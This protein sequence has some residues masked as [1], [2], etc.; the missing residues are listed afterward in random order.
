MNYIDVIKTFSPLSLDDIIKTAKL[1]VPIAYQSVPW[2]YPGLNHGTAILQDEEQLC[3]YLAAYGEMH[4]GKL[5]CALEK[6][7]FKS[8]D[9]NL[10]II[11]WG[12]G[13]GLASVYMADCLRHFGL[14][15]KLQKVTLIEPSTVALS[16]AQLH[17][18]QAVGNDVCLE[19]LNCY[20]PSIG[21]TMHEKS[22]DKL[23]IEE[24]ICIHLFSNILDIP[25]IDLKKLALLVS[26]SGY[27]HYFVCVGPVNF[28][29]DRLSAFPRYFDIQQGNFFIDFKAGQ[30]RQLPSGK[31]YGC[32]AKGFQILREEGKPFLI[33]LSYYPPKQFRSAFRLDVIEEIDKTRI[34]I[35]GYWNEYSAFE[36]LAP[37][38][39]GASIYEDID[40]LLAVLSNIVTRGLPTKC[41]PFIEDKINEVFHCSEITER[42]GTIRYGIKK[43]TNLGNEQLLRDIP[44]AISRIEKVIIEAVLT[45]HISLSKDVWNVVVKEN[46]VPCSAMAFADLAMMYNHLAALSVD[47]KDRKFPKV[48]LNVVSKNYSSSLLHLDSVVFSNIKQVNKEAV[49][50]MVI[51]ISI[52]EKVDA[53]HVQFSEFKA[54]NDCYF[55]VRSSSVVNTPR[56]IY[57]TDRILYQPLTIVNESGGHDVIKKNEEHL[58]YFLQLLFRKK[59][60]RAGQLPIL[61]RAL[62][63][64]GVI[65]LLP[66]GGGKSLTYQMAAMLQPGVTIVIDPLKS[67]MQDQYDGLI[68]TGIDCC[69]Y[70]NSELSSEERAAHELMM[71]TSQVIFAFMSPERLC[72]YEF[73]ERLQN[74]ENLHVYFSYGVIDEVHCVSEWGQDFRF[75]Y[76]HLGRNLYSYVKAKNG[77]ISLFGLTA[78]ASFDVL[79]DVERELSGNGAFVLDSD[80]IVRYENCNRLELQYKVEKIEVDYAEDLSYRPTG[81]LAS[82]GKAVNIGDTFS[83]ND[84]KA[85]FLS[86]Y[87][88]KIPAY[89]R[90]LQTDESVNRILSR[91]EERENLELLDGSRLHVDMPDD[92]YQKNE[93]YEQAGIV[94]CPH[95]NSTGISVNVNS[96]NLSKICEVGTF[97]GSDK[98]GVAQGNESMENMK[99]FR[100][101][102]LPLMV[103]T[104]A[105]GMGIDKPN[106]RFTVNMNYSSSLECFVQ[107]AGRAG[108]DRKMALSV[109]LL[110]D[111]TLYRVSDRCQNPNYPMSAIKNRWFKQKDLR[112]I[113]DAYHIHVDESEFDICTPLTDIVRLKCNTDNT[114]NADGEE[115]MDKYG[116][117]RRQYW[118][119]S[120]QCSRYD[121]CSLRLVNKDLQRKWMYIEDLKRYLET[122]HIRIPKEN[123]EYQGADYNTVMYFFDNNFK[124]EFEEKKKMNFLLSE[125]E[126]EYFIGNDKKD[127]PSEHLQAKGF[128]ETVLNSCVGTEVVS[129]ISYQDDSYADIAKAIYRMC[130]IGLIDD[131]TQDYAAQTFRILS[132]RKKDGSYY[133]RLKEFLMRYY[134]EERAENEVE[135]ASMKKG[136][137]EIHKCLGY[138]TE[139]IYDKVAL[140][141]KRAIDDIRNFCNVGI[142][143]TTGKNWLEINEDLK[144][145]IYYYFNS[146]YA[147]EGYK[148]DN[149]EEFSLLDDTERGKVSSKGILFKYMRV[150]DD[151]VVGTSGSPKDNIKHLQGAVRLIRRSLADTNAALSM[152][153]A[154]CLIVLKVGSNPHLMQELDKSYI[155]GYQ[156]M[157]HDMKDYETFFDCIKE[158]KLSLN[159]NNRNLA[160][161]EDLKHLDELDM[162]AEL[163]DHKTWVNGFMNNYA[164]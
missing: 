86:T 115:E 81:S 139:F 45:G 59:G 149:D 31:W 83:V 116:H 55:N 76:L 74:M 73:R 132:T 1:Y 56:E 48:N 13:Q 43:N 141:R 92:F 18:Q 123:L 2:S 29:N 11:D 71:E 8:I 127:K 129:L 53:V 72:I 155:E 121:K 125:I 114:K 80:A 35:E 38:D 16:R 88:Q 78:T 98:D 95:V 164:K 84:Q 113:L 148:T 105:F 93:D 25:E 89:I 120:P 146:K 57:T 75:S 22:L 51:D 62:Q 52:H 87:I 46:D 126:L 135:K 15:D 99:K 94:F 154:F 28:G 79:S 23:H 110:S 27:R 91:F 117:V 58:V 14:I 133:E 96:G 24:P 161:S 158:F 131:F 64:K 7:P 44:I 109:I 159:A 69:T 103:A 40:P 70:I 145:E 137:N 77:A 122:N 163:D 144:D 65:G 107:E 118:Q 3:C 138:L 5:K 151:D 162:I 21:S 49:Y 147:R 130:V 61:N 47:F 67:L 90:E 143:T 9:N 37:F 66:T 104:K 111:Y 34:D 134:S 140:K 39:I 102:K 128:L 106:V 26:S 54:S 50:D 41:S 112:E 19:D 32:V 82:Y 156:A 36:V 6:F 150:V 157:K 63:I 68:N 10:E 160:S 20:L 42:Y 97:S 100:E 108:R 33:P 119:C 153:N 152:L 17:V 136:N 124:G 4:K 142:D 30:Y 85:K 12:C 60:F 101:N